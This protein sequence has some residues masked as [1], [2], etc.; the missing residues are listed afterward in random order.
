MGMVS[1]TLDASVPTHVSKATTSC[2]AVAT[3]VT[4]T[5]PPSCSSLASSVDGSV[6]CM[7]D[8]SIYV[9]VVNA[10]NAAG[11]STPAMG[12]SYGN[13][14]RCS[15]TDDATITGDTDLVGA[16]ASTNGWC[17]TQALMLFLGSN[18]KGSRPKLALQGV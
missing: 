5:A 11:R 1:L 6:D 4:R 13:T 16:K 9:A 12:T 3:H 10:A 15:P 7:T 17:T 8:I 18:S 2:A 14:V